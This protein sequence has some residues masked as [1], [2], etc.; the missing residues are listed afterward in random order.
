ME[1]QE[2]VEE[3]EQ[4]EGMEEGIRPPQ[5]VVTLEEMEEQGLKMR[6]ISQRQLERK[7]RRTGSAT[8]RRQKKEKS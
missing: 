8:E 2:E 7:K 3:K 6:S 5:E 1:N 4:E